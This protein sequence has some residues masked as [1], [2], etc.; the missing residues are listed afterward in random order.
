MCPR[1]AENRKATSRWVSSVLKSFI[2]SNPKG[3]A[4]LFKNELQ[5]RYAIKVDSQAVY[6]AKRIVLE[7]LK[8]DHAKTYAKIRKYGNVI[9]VM[10]PGSDVFVA[11]NPHVVSVNLTFFRFYISFKSNPKGKAKL[12]KNELQDRYAVKVDS[13]TVYRA[14]RIVLEALKFDHAK[15]YAKIRKYGNV[16]RVMNPGSD[17]FVAINPHVV[18]VNLTFFRFYLSF[19]FGGVVL[20]ATTLDGDSGIVP[21]AMCIYESETTESWTWLLR[22]LHESLEWEE[23]RPICFISY[24][25]KKG[26]AALS[27]EWPEAS[28]RYC[29]R[30]IIANFISTFKNHNINGKLW[31]AARVA[32]CG[33]FN[34]AMASI[35][36]ENA[37]AA[38]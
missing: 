15:A 8:F 3:K 10:N 16:I 4:K 1:V 29:F 35:R 28:N 31:H 21:I 36:S 6:R 12:F 7:A 2:Q 34:E 9:R 30:H 23:G 25:K 24:R 5:D 22:L 27:Q 32:N 19:K 11:I 37:N 20:S 18:S 38:D 33:Y 26:L 14:K 13:Q 17:V